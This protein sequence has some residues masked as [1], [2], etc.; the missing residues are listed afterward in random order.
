MLKGY[1]EFE[2]FNRNIRN[3]SIS[4]RLIKFKEFTII[5][6][7]LKQLSNYLSLSNILLNHLWTQKSFYLYI[8]RYEIGYLTW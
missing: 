3:Q 2:G 5:Y 6:M 1:L 7:K 4:L 8:I